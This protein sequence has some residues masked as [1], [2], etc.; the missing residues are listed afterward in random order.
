MNTFFSVISER[1]ETHILLPFSL[2]L[3]CLDKTHILLPLSPGFRCLDKGRI[4]CLSFAVHC[5]NHHH[6]LHFS[7]G[8]LAFA[9]YVTIA[10]AC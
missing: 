6:T 9:F 1:S 7:T 2:G 10:E 4:I 5:F 3:H 8:K